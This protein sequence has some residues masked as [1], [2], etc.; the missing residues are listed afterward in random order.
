MPQRGSPNDLYTV[1]EMVFQGTAEPVW[2]WPHAILVAEGVESRPTYRRYTVT[3]SSTQGLVFR[4]QDPYL[5]IQD[6][7]IVLIN[8]LYR[9]GWLVPKEGE[10]KETALAWFEGMAG[11][12][13]KPPLERIQR[14][15]RKDPSLP[16]TAS[17]ASKLFEDLASS[18]SEY[19]IPYVS[20]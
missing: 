1:W 17:W 20:G 16:F 6:G 14:Y 8:K 4:K 12:T 13:Q 15:A 2:R 19:W 5:F 9:R 18:G 3:Q 10:P 11:I 7:K